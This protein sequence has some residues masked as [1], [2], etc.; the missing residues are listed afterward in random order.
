MMEGDMKMID[1][2]P[3]RGLKKEEGVADFKTSVS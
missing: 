1:S 3:S 2:I